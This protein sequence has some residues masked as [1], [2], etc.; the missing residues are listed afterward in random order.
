MSNTLRTGWLS[1]TGEFFECLSYDHIMC[2]KELAEPLNLSDYDF[3][4]NRRISADDM[5]M[6]CGWVYIGISSFGS[7]E[8]RIGWK[9]HLTPEQRLFL[10]NY[11]E[12]GNGI[13]VNEI[14][15]MR[16]EDD[17]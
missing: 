5:L 16:W 12:D 15:V 3:I 2:A 14:S 11:F 1:P 7:H 10:K 4:T 13:P 9:T 8:W 17:C 6:N